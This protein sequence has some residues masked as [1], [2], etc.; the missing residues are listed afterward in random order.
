MLHG[1]VFYYFVVGCIYF[2]LFQ[3]HF[4]FTQK[5]QQENNLGNLSDVLK[6]TY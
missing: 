4:M 6:I 1:S 5:I 2:F 3:G